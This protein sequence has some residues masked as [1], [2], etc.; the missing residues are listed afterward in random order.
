MAVSITCSVVISGGWRL[1]MHQLS[2]TQQQLADRERVV[3]PLREAEARLAELQSRRQAI[4]AQEDIVA[5]LE[6]SIP[7]A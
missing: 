2:R 6:A 4:N 5:R 7:P 3:Q 1:K